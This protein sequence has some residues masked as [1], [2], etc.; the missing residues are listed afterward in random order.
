MTA[1]I[2]GTNGVTTP[3]V[4][5]S[6][7]GVA[8]TLQSG[9]TTAVTIDT[10]QNL[11]IG[12]TSPSNKLAVSQTVSGADAKVR[13]FNT[14]T[15]ASS[16]SVIDLS[17]DGDLKSAWRY[18]N[19]T[20]DTDFGNLLGAYNLKFYTNAT[21]RVRIDSSGN[22]NIKTSN[23]G[24]VFNNSNALTNSTLNDYEYGTFTVTDASGA[25]LTFT[26][27]TGYYTKVGRLV[28]VTF[29]IVY[30]ATASANNAAISLPFTAATSGKAG[31]GAI[32]YSTVAGGIMAY[33]GTTSAITFY[34][35]GT[36]IAQTNSQLSGKELSVVFT[37]QANF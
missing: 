30:P 3:N 22:L 9:G 17:N 2:D 35:I 5:T 4:L 31:G 24:I 32:S 25:G 33:Q 27:N 10:S 19:N 37:L 8:L 20:G 14:A 6:S 28:T 21:E 1:I 36:G 7:S 13:F 23:A 18:N 15:A 26:A 11:G 29:D 12:T 34:A 16:G